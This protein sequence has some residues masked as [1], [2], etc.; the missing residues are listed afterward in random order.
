M[1]LYC[2]H[3][4]RW[5]EYR[6]HQQF[7]TLDYAAMHARMQRPS[8]IFDGRSLLNHDALRKIGFQ[9]YCIGQANDI[10]QVDLESF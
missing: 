4:F 1:D 10:N 6:S 8:F 2:S 3:S 5:V 9:V 7:T